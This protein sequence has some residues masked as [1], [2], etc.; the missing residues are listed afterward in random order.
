VV[1]APMLKEI[2]QV[3]D[4][5]HGWRLSLDQLDSSD[6]ATF[7]ADASSTKTL[8]LMRKVIVEATASLGRRQQNELKRIQD[9]PAAARKAIEIMVSMLE[10]QNGKQSNETTRGSQSKP[11]T[12]RSSVNA[13]KQRNSSS[14][15]SSYMRPSKSAG[16]LNSTQRKRSSLRSSS[17]TSTTLRSLIA[18]GDFSDVLIGYK[19]ETLLLNGS[20]LDIL[21]QQTKVLA[22]KEVR[23]ASAL[24]GYL[25]TW[26]LMHIRLAS[27]LRNRVVGLHA[28]RDNASAKKSLEELDNASGQ[29]LSRMKA[30]FLGPESHIPLDQVFFGTGHSVAE[31][32]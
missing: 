4:M 29:T 8:I 16:S 24:C 32:W 11:S 9:P 6:L 27:A 22:H 1:V 5:I 10:L 17:K 3:Q 2:L 25:Y 28:L 15:S 23:R 18:K 7:H 26:A 13:R 30:H 12:R 21:H 31:N 19:S 14:S 20:Q